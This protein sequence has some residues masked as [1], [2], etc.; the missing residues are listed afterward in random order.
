M[1]LAAW[2]HT[3]AWIVSLPKHL[4]V[5]SQGQSEQQLRGSRMRSA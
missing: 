5:Q 3:N 2:L 4:W 1:R